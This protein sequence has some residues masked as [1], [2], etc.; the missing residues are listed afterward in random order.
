MPLECP[1][2]YP[3]T[4]IDTQPDSI[5][6]HATPRALKAGVATLPNPAANETPPLLSEIRQRD[7]GVRSTWSHWD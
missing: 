2:S 5:M 6:N 1:F 7:D 4:I 3:V